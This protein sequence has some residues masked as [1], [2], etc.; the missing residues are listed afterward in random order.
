MIGFW[1]VATEMFAWPLVMYYIGRSK[2]YKLGSGLASLS[3]V[4]LTWTVGFIG[5]RLRTTVLLNILMYFSFLCGGALSIGFVEQ[6]IR[7][8]KSN[9]S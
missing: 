7:N 1:L 6:L 4:S 5:V 3:L 9:A 2:R 8:R